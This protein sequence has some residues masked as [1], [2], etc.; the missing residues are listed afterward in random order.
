MVCTERTSDKLERLGLPLNNLP[1]SVLRTTSSGLL[2]GET[3]LDRT[4]FHFV[5]IIGSRIGLGRVPRPIR[6]L[7]THL[8]EPSS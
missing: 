3:L 1:L 2:E 8:V 7:E 5:K 4:P 6:G